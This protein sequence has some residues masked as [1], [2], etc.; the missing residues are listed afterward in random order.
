MERLPEEDRDEFIRNH[1]EML[2]K[3][4]AEGDR[5]NFKVFDIDAVIEKERMMIRT[6]YKRD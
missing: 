4:L 5:I 2:E 6:L 1:K 3:A